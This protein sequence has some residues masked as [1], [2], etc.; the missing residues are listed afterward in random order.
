[1]QG[2]NPK[3]PT[4]EKQKIEKTHVKEKQSYAQNNIYVI[5]QFAYIHRVARISLL[6]GKNTKCG[7]NIFTHLET[8][9]QHPP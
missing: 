8:R 5:R 7:Y 6:S 1:M 4:C 2:I 9:Q 3:F